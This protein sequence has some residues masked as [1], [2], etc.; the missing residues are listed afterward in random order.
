MRVD[1]AGDTA[2]FRRVAI[3]EDLQRKGHGRTLLS[4]AEQFAGA[5]GC[6]Q[7]CSNVGPGAV[8]FYRKV[9][10]RERGPALDG[11]SVPM[12]KAL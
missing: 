1:V 9:G 11:G 8:E 4:L 5:Q 2:F 3:R 7:A 12:Q 6:T 10:Y